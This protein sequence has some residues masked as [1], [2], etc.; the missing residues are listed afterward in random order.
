MHPLT[1]SI[2]NPDGAEQQNLARSPKNRTLLMQLQHFY[3]SVRAS[4]DTQ[5]ALNQSLQILLLYEQKVSTGT[6]IKKG[7]QK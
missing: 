5:R 1:I 2:F 4:A 3:S 6:L 7:D